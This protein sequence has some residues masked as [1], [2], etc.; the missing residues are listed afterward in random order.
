MNVRRVKSKLLLN[1]KEISQ[2]FNF[3]V[4]K[5]INVI[6]DTAY[7]EIQ[8]PYSKTNKLVLNKKDKIKIMMS[9]NETLTLIFEG[10]I[11]NIQETNNFYKINCYNNVLLENT[12]FTTF[13]NL[14]ASQIFTNICDVNYQATDT[15]LESFIAEGTKKK[16]LYNLIYTIKEILKTP[17]YF[18][19]ENNIVVIKNQLD[20]NV[21]LIDDVIRKVNLDKL[22]IFPIKEIRLGDSVVYNNTNYKVVGIQYTQREMV[23]TVG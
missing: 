10:E 2:G 4:I 16:S 21:H 5:S 22:T 20:G 6:E 12:L 8:K 14:Q 18:Y 17:F 15:L 23:L 19:N 13:E 1:N 11:D 7:I 3:V 9:T